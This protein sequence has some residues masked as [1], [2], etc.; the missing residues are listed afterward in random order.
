MFIHSPIVEHLG[1]FQLLPI[2]SN[3]AMKIC[4]KFCVDICFDFLEQISSYR[5]VGFYDIYLYAYDTHI[6]IFLKFVK[7]FSKVMVP[8]CIFHSSETEF[9]FF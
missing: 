5:M 8:F 4:E 6:Y 7:L 9:Q 1:Y 2:A 3:A